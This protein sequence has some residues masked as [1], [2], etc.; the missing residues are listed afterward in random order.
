MSQPH[1]RLVG[2]VAMGGVRGAHR[3]RP[4]ARLPYGD[5]IVTLARA[6]TR[7]YYGRTNGGALAGVPDSRRTDRLAPPY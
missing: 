1:S 2:L 6:K 3:A 5:V 4:L 7:P